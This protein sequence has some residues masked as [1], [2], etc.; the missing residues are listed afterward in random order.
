M[1]RDIDYFDIIKEF[2][3]LQYQLC[4]LTTLVNSISVVSSGTEVVATKALV[5][6]STAVRLVYVIVDETNN[7]DISLYFYNGSQLK[8]LQTVTP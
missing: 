7:G 3:K 1:G 6:T 5:S 4:C 2:G 8:F